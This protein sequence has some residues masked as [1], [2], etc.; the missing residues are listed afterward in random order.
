MKHYSDDFKIKIIELVKIGRSISDLS[1]EY[2]IP[3]STIATWNRYYKNNESF[4]FNDTFSDTEKELI[5]LK[6]EN[7]HLKM[8]NDILKQSA[9]IMGQKGK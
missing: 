2:N 5:A 8:E 4:R 3:T 7:K 9:L 6:K 1:R